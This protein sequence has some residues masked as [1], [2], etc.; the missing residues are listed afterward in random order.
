MLE[1][2]LSSLEESNSTPIGNGKIDLIYDP[3]TKLLAIVGYRLGEDI[4]LISGDRDKTMCHP[5]S[6]KRAKKEYD[7]NLEDAFVAGI[8]IAK[9]NGLVLILNSKSNTYPQIS[10]LNKKNIDILKSSFNGIEVMTIEE[11]ESRYG[12]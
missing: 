1:N 9:N 7:L 5:T 10:G 11:V 6:A 3:Q 4:Y 12:I 2:S 8:G